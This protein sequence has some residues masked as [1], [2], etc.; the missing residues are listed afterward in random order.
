MTFFV[1]APST[2]CCVY[3]IVPDPT[4][5]SGQIE[6]VDCAQNISPGFSQPLLIDDTIVSV[7]N[8]S[9]ADGATEVPMSNPLI[10]WSTGGWPCFWLGHYEVYFGTTPDPPLFWAG[11]ETAFPPGMLQHST[12]YYWRVE[13]KYGQ[14]CTMSAGPLWSFTTEQPIG[15]T[16]STWGAIKALFR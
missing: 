1:I 8:P 13:E 6:I 7:G 11:I 3:D 15:T 5:P 14:N 12:T 16:P 4:A 10:S 2:A 9:P